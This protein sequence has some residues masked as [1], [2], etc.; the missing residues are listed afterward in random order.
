MT[1]L[2]ISQLCETLLHEYGLTGKWTEMTSLVCY[3]SL[4]GNVV[5]W[6]CVLLKVLDQAVFL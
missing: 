1:L 2:T 4:I 3:Y 6:V 5:G